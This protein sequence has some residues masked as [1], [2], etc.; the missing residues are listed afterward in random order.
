M[1]A[2]A[3]IQIKPIRGQFLRLLAQISGARRIVEIGTFTGYSSLCF[4]FA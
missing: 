3:N 2:Q 1:G 4:A